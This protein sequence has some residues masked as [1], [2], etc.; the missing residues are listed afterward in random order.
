VTAPAQQP[1]LPGSA[2][3]AVRAAVRAGVA[4]VPSGALVLVALSGGPDSLALARACAV[5]LPS[6]GRRA[7]AVVVDHG[8]QPASAQVAAHAA[9]QGRELG[10]DPVVVRQVEVA[11]GPGHGGP[12]LR[13]AARCRAR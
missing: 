5:E 1:D 8:L 4:D 11:A 10:L 6:R 3:L 13:R 9:R 12:G 2:L 7:G